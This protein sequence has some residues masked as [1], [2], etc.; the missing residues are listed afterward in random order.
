MLCTMEAEWRFPDRL[1]YERMQQHFALL[2]HAEGQ[3]RCLKGIFD[4]EDEH[5]RDV[6]EMR[7]RCVRDAS[8]M[9]ISRSCRRTAEPALHRAGTLR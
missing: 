8:E 3:K 5:R 2:N 9:A 7:A 1:G 4:L 6:C